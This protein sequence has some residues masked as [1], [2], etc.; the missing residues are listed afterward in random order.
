MSA[1]S[2]RVSRPAAAPTIARR[3]RH[4]RVRSDDAVVTV[5]FA[6]GSEPFSAA[7]ACMSA[8]MRQRLQN[9]GLAKRLAA[10]ASRAGS[11]AHARQL[12]VEEIERL[13]Q[14]R[15]GLRPETGP[16]YSLL[17]Q[18]V[19][20]IQV[21]A[22]SEAAKRIRA[23]SRSDRQR[24]L[25]SP[26]VRQTME[27]LRALTDEGRARDNIAFQVLAQDSTPAVN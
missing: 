16:R 10:A 19:A 4:I 2:R 7:S 22:P 12:I 18:A 9:Y 21:I 11:T 25:Q 26:K 23:L 15:W 5:E 13:S 27:E 17:A 8:P 20:N 3:E 14:G 6:D 24:L 1:K